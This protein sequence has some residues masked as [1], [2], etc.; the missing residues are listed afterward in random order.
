MELISPS[1]KTYKVSEC[2]GETDTYTLYECVLEGEQTAILKIVK[3]KDQNGKLDREAY[4]LNT[5]KEKAIQLD[6]EGLGYIRFFPTIIETFIVPEQGDRRVII[7]S[8]SEVCETLS[9]LTPLGRILST[10]RKRIDPKTSVWILGRLLKLLHFAHKLGINVTLNGEN[11]LINRDRHHVTIFDWSDSTNNVDEDGAKNQ[12]SDA[13][14]EVVCALGGDFE[15]QTI[16]AD[17]DLE[18][19]WYQDLVFGF[20][21]GCHDDAGKAHTV[22]YEIVGSKWPSKFYLFTAYPVK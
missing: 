17:K 21:K 20:V 13:A 15:T 16:P 2:I 18:D 7:L 12:I 4:F 6:T 5:L 1:G 3:S 19:D 14:T 10:E 22:F 11:I 8:F 9:E